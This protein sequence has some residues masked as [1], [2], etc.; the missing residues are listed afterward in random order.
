MRGKAY[1]LLSCIMHMHIMLPHIIMTGIPMPIME[2][3]RSQHSFII[4]AVVLPIGVILQTMALPDISQCIVI[5][6][7]IMGIIIGIVWPCII[8]C[9]MGCII[10]CIPGIMADIIFIPGI[11]FI[12]GMFIMGM[13]FII[14]WFP[15]FF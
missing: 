12:A 9:I 2:F 1:F 10:C 13:A 15:C 5:V 8:A 11:M 7:G 6:I 14:F 3:M 4:S